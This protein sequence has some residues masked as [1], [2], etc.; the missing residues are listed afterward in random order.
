LLLL[1]ILAVG[2]LQVSSVKLRLRSQRGDPD[3]VSSRLANISAEVTNVPPGLSVLAGADFRIDVLRHRLFEVQ[4]MITS[5][6]KQ[7]HDVERSIDEAFD[8]MQTQYTAYVKLFE[9]NQILEPERRDPGPLLYIARHVAEAQDRHFSLTSAWME[10]SPVIAND[11]V[12][13][14]QKKQ[15]IEQ[16][17]AQ[18]QAYLAE[19][20][21]KNNP[22]PSLSSPPSVKKDASAPA[23]AMK[24]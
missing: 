12:N 5:K 4:A 19:L 2:F 6:E 24:L 8:E 22:L 15:I 10:T 13:L 20:T 1:S 9:R 16:A 23:V 11:L 21:L 17:I 7:R 3:D 14:Q 18:Q